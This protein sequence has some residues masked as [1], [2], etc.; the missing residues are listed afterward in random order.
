MCTTK[1]AYQPPKMCSRHRS[2]K[3]VYHHCGVEETYHSFFFTGHAKLKRS[4]SLQSLR[5]IDA[6]QNCMTHCNSNCM[7]LSCLVLVLSINCA[8]TFPSNTSTQ[9]ERLSPFLAPGS[10]TKQPNHCNTSNT[11]AHGITNTNAP[12][13]KELTVE[14]VPARVCFNQHCHGIYFPKTPT[15]IPQMYDQSSS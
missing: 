13:A 2:K 8:S 1:N 9:P 10:R 3:N 4:S 14:V 15:R 7:L 11:C 5:C 6:C 12:P